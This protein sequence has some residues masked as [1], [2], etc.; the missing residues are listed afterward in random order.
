MCVN[1][2]P[3]DVKSFLVRYFSFLKLTIVAL[4]FDID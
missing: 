4:V 3:S 2:M 1:L